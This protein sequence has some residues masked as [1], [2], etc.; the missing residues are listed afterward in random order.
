M[1]P[2]DVL[3]VKKFFFYS[4]FNFQNPTGGL[5]VDDPK[6]T[7]GAGG[8]HPSNGGVQNENV[9]KKLL[10]ALTMR[11]FLGGMASKC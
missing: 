11:I 7:I 6:S 4:V 2:L 5:R 1:S 10:T 9:K 3:P 8:A